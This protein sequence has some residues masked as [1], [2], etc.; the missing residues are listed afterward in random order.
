MHLNKL[1]NTEYE[2]IKDFIKELAQIAIEHINKEK[3]EYI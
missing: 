3:E 1:K 2:I